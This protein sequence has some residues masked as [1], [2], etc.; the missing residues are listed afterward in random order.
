MV[1]ESDI[2]NR[3]RNQ[4]VLDFYRHFHSLIGLDIKLA[5]P[6]DDRVAALHNYKHRSLE[7]EIQ[8]AERW[9]PVDFAHELI[10]AKV[11]FI[12][13]YGIID[14]NIALCA[15]IRKYIEDIVVHRMIHDEFSMRPYGGFY[16]QHTRKKLT[17]GMTQGNRITNKDWDNEGPMCNEL[18][19]ALLYVQAWHFYQLEPDTRKVLKSFLNSFRKVY[20]ASTEMSLAHR[21]ID[22]YKS[23]SEFMDASAYDRGLED[24]LKLSELN[25]PPGTRVKHFQKVQT[26]GYDLL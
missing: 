18:Q 12:D 25:F 1:T 20:Q 23:N 13:G 7:F 22:I 8:L 24:I 11:M 4:S 26:G 14:C 6:A 17:S 16:L 2:M 15:L 10:H 5:E 3:I 21:L 9:E 19:K